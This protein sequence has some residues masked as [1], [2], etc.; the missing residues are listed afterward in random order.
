MKQSANNSQD[1]TSQITS[2]LIKE[3][4]FKHKKRCKTTNIHILFANMKQK[5]ALINSKYPRQGANGRIHFNHTELMYHGTSWKREIREPQLIW[6]TNARGRKRGTARKVKIKMMLR[7]FNYKYERQRAN[8]WITSYNLL[9]DRMKTR[10][11]SPV[12]TNQS[13]NARGRACRRKMDPF[14]RF[15]TCKC[16][17]RIET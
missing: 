6:K 3:S 11:Q 17:F 1:Q 5:T 7:K 16:E 14:T 13:I 15:T 12:L 9:W 2:I 8:A 4:Q 10:I